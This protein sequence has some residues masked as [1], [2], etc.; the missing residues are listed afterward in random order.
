MYVDW[1][2]ESVNKWKYVNKE[3]LCNCL[4]LIEGLSLC[5]I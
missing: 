3:I 4:I 2:V 1:R 5:W